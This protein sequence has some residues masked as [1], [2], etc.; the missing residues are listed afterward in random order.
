MT[1]EP[2]GGRADEVADGALRGQLLVATPALE[3][4]N[5][6]RAV[7]LILEH[8]ADGAIGVVLNR[9]SQAPLAEALPSWQLAVSDPQVVFVGGPVQRTAALGLGWVP[10]G[11]PGGGLRVL[12]DC[13]G[14]LDLDSDPGTLPLAGARV[15]AGYAGWGGGQ[16]EAEI[17]TGSWYVLEALPGDAFTH[18][19]DRLW[20]IVLRRQGGNLAFVSLFPDDPTMN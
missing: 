9:P 8:N 5:F 18:A 1:D 19:P 2:A 11:M 17:A 14:T 13:V 4:P 7:V 10:R 20:R 12:D 15:F 6:R 16:L 3:D